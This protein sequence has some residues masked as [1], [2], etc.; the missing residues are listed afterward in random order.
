[1]GEYL[2]VIATEIFASS[3]MGWN[4]FLPA[5]SVNYTKQN[6]N[7]G[8]RDN[9]IVTTLR[10]KRAHTHSYGKNSNWGQFQINPT[11]YC[12]DER[13]GHCVHQN[14][15]IQ[16]MERKISMMR[17]L[18]INHDFVSV[19]ALSP[20]VQSFIP[21]ETKAHFHDYIWSNSEMYVA[22][23]M[24]IN[25]LTATSKWHSWNSCRQ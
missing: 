9:I 22:I 10:N 23:R 13:V 15:V 21:L 6:P 8:C 11:E 5:F 4:F 1:M 2:E 24:I 17:Q 18:D 25:I 12:W 7:F 20:G 19:N 14:P 16:I 3:K